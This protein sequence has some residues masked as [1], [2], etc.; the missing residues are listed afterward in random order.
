MTD[1]HGP[2]ATYRRIQ[3]TKRRTLI[4][5]G[6]FMA[7]TLIGCST[8]AEVAGE[9]TA[10]AVRSGEFARVSDAA[11]C[12]ERLGGPRAATLLDRLAPHAGPTASEIMRQ[13][14]KQLEKDSLALVEG[15][16]WRALTG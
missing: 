8:A 9:L 3:R 2:I 7:V 10:E 5:A 4:G 16:C 1:V 6:L 11:L 14:A 12:L 13:T 15:A